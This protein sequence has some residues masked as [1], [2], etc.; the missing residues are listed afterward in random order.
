MTLPG[1]Q[2]KARRPVQGW[3]A[4]FGLIELIAVLVR[5]DTR[6]RDCARDHLHR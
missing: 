2:Y 5:G 4:G 6:A 1:S 3:A